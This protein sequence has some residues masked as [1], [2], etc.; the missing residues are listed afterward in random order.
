MANPNPSITNPNQA[1]VSQSLIQ[2]AASKGRTKWLQQLL[3]NHLPRLSEPSE[4][5]DAW[6]DELIN[7]MEARGLVNPT[8]QKD[9]LTDVRGAIKV[10]DPSHPAL[11]IVGFS[12]E[13]WTE[14]NNRNS[15]SIAQR[16][17]KLL[18]NPDA[19]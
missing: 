11:N 18:K 9:Y 2:I 14:I 19:I 16:T 7:K 12:K 5:Y 1:T 10:L 3:L 13:T 4:S 15:S 6:F 17:T 8:Q